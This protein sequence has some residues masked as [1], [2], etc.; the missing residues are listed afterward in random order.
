M[1]AAALVYVGMMQT[2]QTTDEEI[3]DP[4]KVVT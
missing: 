3:I 2:D 4:G 1:A